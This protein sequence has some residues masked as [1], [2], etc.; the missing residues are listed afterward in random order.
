MELFGRL[1]DVAQKSSD[2]LTK[3]YHVRSIA[4]PNLSQISIPLVLGTS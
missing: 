3:R 4:Y 1:K 2:G